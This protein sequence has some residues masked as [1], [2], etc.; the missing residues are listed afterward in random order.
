M[1]INKLKIS[2]PISKL[3]NVSGSNYSKLLMEIV[4]DNYGNNV[5]TNKQVPLEIFGDFL[6]SSYP[7]FNKLNELYNDKTIV[8][9]DDSGTSSYRYKS[10]L[11]ISGQTYFKTNP[12][13]YSESKVDSY[14]RLDSNNFVQKQQ[15]EKYIH[16]NCLETFPIK[17]DYKCMQIVKK[18][19][20]TE[21]ELI[22]DETNFSKCLLE[23]PS[24]KGKIKIPLFNGRLY[25]TNVMRLPNQK[26]SF[27]TIVGKVR[28]PEEITT[29]T[30]RYYTPEHNLWAGILYL[31]N[32]IAVTELHN[33]N[34]GIAY[35]SFQLPS[36]HDGENTYM[37][38]RVVVPFKPAEALENDE[39]TQ[40]DIF[41]NIPVNS[42]AM[43]YYQ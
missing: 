27:V 41:K 20:W 15:L 26:S 32:L 7:I 34:D 39:K 38:I 22:Y 29:N 10:D 4:V 13:L 35:F 33:Y 8:D 14:A 42:I 43:F 12:S 17:S 21:A 28:V 25:G 16:S 31:D 24:V 6:I 3:S 1:S 36:A 37:R 11:Y 19:E 9:Y 18:G 40:I 5:Y 23:T 30:T 2:Y